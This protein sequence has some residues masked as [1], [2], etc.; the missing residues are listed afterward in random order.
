[1][2]NIN[3]LIQK[4]KIINFFQIKYVN[5]YFILYN[6]YFKIAPGLNF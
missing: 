2:I 6:K 3:F 4:I 1:M 5:F